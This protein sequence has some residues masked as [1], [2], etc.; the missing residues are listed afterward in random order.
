MYQQITFSIREV[1]SGNIIYVELFSDRLIDLSELKRLAKE[2]NMPVATQNTVAF[3]EGTSLI[4]F[5]ILD[6]S[7]SSGST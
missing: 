4:D 7:S 3:P 2:F 6:T 1:K 5:S